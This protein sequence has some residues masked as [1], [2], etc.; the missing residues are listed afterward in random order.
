[1]QSFVLEEQ[2]ESARKHYSR[3]EGSACDNNIT[4]LCTNGIFNTCV[5]RLTIQV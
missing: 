5:L 2:F 1:M 4:N 3:R